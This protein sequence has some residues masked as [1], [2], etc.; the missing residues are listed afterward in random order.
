MLL[1]PMAGVAAYGVDD[2]GA[3]GAWGEVFPVDVGGHT[4]HFAGG[5]FFGFGIAA[6]IDFGG[7]IGAGGVTEI[8][9]NTQCVVVF[10]H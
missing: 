8:T 6:E 7:I 1:S 4:H 2:F 10:V 5:F 3:I 9:F